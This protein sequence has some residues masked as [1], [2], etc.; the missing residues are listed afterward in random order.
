MGKVG[1]T[2][3]CLAV[4]AG[5]GLASEVAPGDVAIDG[6]GHV[7]APLTDA[8]GDPA[9]GRS[10]MTN[11]A[12]ANCIACHQVTE[13]SDAP[14]PGTVGPSLDGVAARYSEAMIRGILV[15]SKNVFPDTVMPAYYRVEGFNRPGIEF[16]SKPIEGEIQPLMTAAQIE[17]VVAYLMTLTQ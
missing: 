4:W 6:Q 10:L 3:F 13:M 14:F 11:R 17:D 1:L 12:V 15:N 2:A 9:A 5:A 16:T 7:A 8:P